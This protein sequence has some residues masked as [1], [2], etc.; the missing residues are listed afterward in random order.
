M[1]ETNLK[2]TG[3]A[4]NGSWNPK[5]TPNPA[6]IWNPAHSPVVEFMLRVVTSPDPIAAIIAPPQI[7]GSFISQLSM[8]NR[9]FK[10]I[11][12]TYIIANLGDKPARKDGPKD[13]QDSIWGVPDT[14]LGC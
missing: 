2:A 3:T 12:C 5:P 1:N 11:L 8:S 13:S 6:R 14:T 4:A 7:K 9:G 10:R